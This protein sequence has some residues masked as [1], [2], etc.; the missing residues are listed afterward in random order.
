M[1]SQPKQGLV[2]FL[3][4]KANQTKKNYKEKKA[5]LGGFHQL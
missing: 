3:I 1:W 5:Y 2:I 4:L